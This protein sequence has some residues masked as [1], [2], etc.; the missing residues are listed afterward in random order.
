MTNIS[1]ERNWGTTLTDNSSVFSQ[2]NSRNFL[3]GHGWKVKTIYKFYDYF[4]RSSNYNFTLSSILQSLCSASTHCLR[5]RVMQFNSVY[6]WLYLLMSCHNSTCPL[7]TRSIISRIRVE[8]IFHTCLLL[9]TGVTNLFQTNTLNIYIAHSSKQG[10]ILETSTYFSLSHTLLLSLFDVQ[11]LECFLVCSGQLVKL[12][13]EVSN[14][15]VVIV[16]HGRH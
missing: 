7:K 11:F 2:S 14:I 4:L 12:S 13:W 15:N 16:S 8:M 3:I 1:C 6:V 9:H 10:W 5:L